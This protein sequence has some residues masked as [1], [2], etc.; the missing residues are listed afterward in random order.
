[1]INCGEWNNIM[2]AQLRILMVFL[3]FI[4]TTTREY[5]RG[6]ILNAVVDSWGR[7]TNNLSFRMGV[8]DPMLF[9]ESVGEMSL[10]VLAR[11]IHGVPTRSDCAKVSQSYEMLKL[12]KEC[13]DWKTQ[14]FEEK[15]EKHDF[16]RPIVRSDS[17]DVAT[18]AAFF[19]KTLRDM[20]AGVWQHYT[21]DSW[22]D[23]LPTT[24][25]LMAG[26]G[27]AQHS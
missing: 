5:I 10:S 20:E 25:D 26:G 11:S 18:C 17:V 12:V 27:N 8:H 3:S 4:G 14:D 2:R 13:C 22:V 24:V 1:M 6:I 23:S 19:K 21:P 7:A 9:N 15:I 16:H